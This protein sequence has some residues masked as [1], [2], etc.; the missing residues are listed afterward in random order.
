MATEISGLFTFHQT[1]PRSELLAIKQPHATS[2]CAPVASAMGA[3]TRPTMPNVFGENA[4][5]RWLE[6]LLFPFQILSILPLIILNHW[7]S[8][9]S[10]KGQSTNDDLFATSAGDERFDLPKTSEPISADEEW[11]CGKRR[12]HNLFVKKGGCVSSRRRGPNREELFGYVT[13]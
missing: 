6:S 12:T 13:V 4:S 3:Q 9:Q 2:V 5:E 11:V 8:W 10:N 1:W 7:A